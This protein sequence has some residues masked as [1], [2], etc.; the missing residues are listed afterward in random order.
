MASPTTGEL[1]PTGDDND[2]S[3]SAVGRFLNSVQLCDSGLSGM[4]SETIKGL[5][6]DA[7]LD[8]YVGEHL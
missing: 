1:Q 4:D 6:T 3:Q 2:L 7:D 8:D 5:Q